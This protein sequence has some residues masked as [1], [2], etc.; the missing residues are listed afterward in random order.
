MR[1]VFSKFT[2]KISAWFQF[3]CFRIIIVKF[4]REWVTLLIFWLLMFWLV[5]FIS[6][7]LIFRLFFIHTERLSFNENI[8]IH[9]FAE[10]KINRC[11]CPRSCLLLDPR[12]E[13]HM[14][15]PLHVS[16]ERFSRTACRNFLIFYMNVGHHLT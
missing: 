16:P 13:G 5:A 14:K 4:E 10:T 11:R 6:K 2:I 9:K 3:R 7:D 15:Y 12:S 1:E 8:A